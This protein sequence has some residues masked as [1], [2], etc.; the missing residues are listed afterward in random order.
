[1]EQEVEADVDSDVEE[2]EMMWSDESDDV[3]ED[4]DIDESDVDDETEEPNL[5]RRIVHTLTQ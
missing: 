1:M 2:P 3:A 4:E 5:P